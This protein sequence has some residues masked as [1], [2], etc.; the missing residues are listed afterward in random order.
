M[1]NR[2]YLWPFERKLT[3]QTLRDCCPGEITVKGSKC[4]RTSLR[5]S[6]VL[7]LEHL[8]S[9]Q[10]RVV[11]WWRNWFFT[12]STV[13]SCLLLTL[14]SLPLEIQDKLNKT[15]EDISKSMTFLKVDQD[16]VKALPSQGLSPAAVLEK[17]KEYSSKGTLLS[18]CMLPTSSR[19]WS[20]AHHGCL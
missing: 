5:K 18:R 15:K 6:T 11:V 13:F 7:V 10:H 8:C 9:A 19:G 17:L 1:G 16:Y 3:L 12:L 4:Q 20:L 14:S 2:V